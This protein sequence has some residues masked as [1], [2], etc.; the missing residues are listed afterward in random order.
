MTRSDPRRPAPGA[1]HPGPG[2]AGAGRP[3]GEVRTRPRP[4]SG[5][6]RR[7]QPMVTLAVT[8]AQAEAVVFGVEHGTLWLSLE[9][10]APHRRHRR[11]TPATSTERLRMSR[12]VLAAADEDLILRVKQAADG[13]VTRAAAGRL[14]TDPARL[15]EQ[16]LD[17]ELPDVLVIGP[18][19]LAGRRPHP[20]RAPGH[21]VARHQRRPDHRGSQQ[22]RQAAMR[23]GIRD[24]LPRRPTSRRSPRRSSAPLAA[25]GRRRVLAR[26]PRPSATPA[27]SSASPRLRAAWARPPSR[28]TWR[29]AWPRRRTRRSWSTSTC[30]SATSPALNLEPEYSLADAVSGPAARTRWC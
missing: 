10:P 7:R 8:A 2:R 27:G 3:G 25:N 13:D 15:F 26:P 6:A 20:G 28:P 9:P 30:S 24:L 18:A 11:L 5:T 23:S 14:P 16:L 12:V 21:P 4:S 22:M 19:R 1:G 17:G 29:S